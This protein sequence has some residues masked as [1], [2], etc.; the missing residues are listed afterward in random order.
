MEK[1]HWQSPGQNKPFDTTL[2]NWRNKTTHDLSKRTIAVLQFIDENPNVE[3]SVFKEEF[4]KYLVEDF[5]P[6]WNISN[7]NF[8]KVYNHYFTHLLF[9]NFIEILDNNNFSNIDSKKLKITDNGKKFL[10]SIFT[11]NYDDALNIYLNQLINSTFVN[12]AT[13][14]VNLNIYPF[15]IIFKILYEYGWVHT[16][17]FRTNIGYINKYDDLKC[18]LN[19]LE[20]NCYLE[21]IKYINKNQDFYRENKIFKISPKQWNMYITSQLVILG[22]FE[23]KVVKKYDYEHDVETEDSYVRLT[24]QGIDFVEKIKLQEEDYESM[25]K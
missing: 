23:E 7:G 5:Y 11:E 6:K 25:F 8:G 16:L 17:L 19:F 21:Y 4:N 13:K 2:D 24:T 14:K 15:K 3:I 10:T 1:V 22:I 12:E 20:N 9:V 18:C